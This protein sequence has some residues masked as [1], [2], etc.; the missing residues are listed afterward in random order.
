[1]SK[2]KSKIT[3]PN[4][5]K[6]LEKPAPQKKREIVGNSIGLILE[7]K[8][9]TQSELADLS[10]LDQNHICRIIN[11]K[12]KQLSMATGFKISHALNMPIEEI[13]ELEE[14]E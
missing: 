7:S 4:I 3:A 14:P 8:Q 10:G 13:F 6:L 5:D 2:K 1:M 12:K 9:M 11:G